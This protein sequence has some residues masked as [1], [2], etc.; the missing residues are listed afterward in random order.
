MIFTLNNIDVTQKQ[1]NPPTS[2]K[3]LKHRLPIQFRT[4]V[5]TDTLTLNTNQDQLSIPIEYI[6]IGF[7]LIEF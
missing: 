7:R 1:D 2:N 6:A 5:K 4:F 3:T